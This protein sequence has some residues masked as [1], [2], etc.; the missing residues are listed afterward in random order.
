M[1]EKVLMVRQAE[2][3]EL[4]HAMKRVEFAIEKVRLFNSPTPGCPIGLA[5]YFLHYQDRPKFEGVITGINA[6]CEQVEQLK[7]NP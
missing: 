5:G 4:L 3:D 2:Y 1:N 7:L 6:L